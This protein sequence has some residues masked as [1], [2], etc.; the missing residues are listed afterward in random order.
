MV[1]NK[2]CNRAY[3]TDNSSRYYRKPMA[4]SLYKRP[5]AL[6]LP[7]ASQPDPAI[8]RRPKRPTLFMNNQVVYGMQQYVPP[9]MSPPTME[10]MAMETP[11]AELPKNY[12]DHLVSPHK[13][14]S[15]GDVN[16]K[17]SNFEEILA[18]FE[19]EN[20][21]QQTGS[22]QDIVKLSKYLKPRVPSS[23]RVRHEKFKSS[24]HSKDGTAKAGPKDDTS[25]NPET[26]EVTA[27]SLERLL[28]QLKKCELHVKGDQ[29]GTKNDAS[30]GD[31]QIENAETGD[32][33]DDGIVNVS[34]DEKHPRPPPKSF[35]YHDISEH[36]M[37][38]HCQFDATD[39]TSSFQDIMKNRTKSA[40]DSTPQK[41]R[42]VNQISRK[43]PMDDHCALE[44]HRSK[45]YIV[46]LIDRA[47]SKE[48][49]TVP[50]ERS[51][52]KFE[53]M[54]P[55]KAINAMNRH[56]GSDEKDIS[57]KITSA[58][59]DSLISNVTAPEVELEPSIRTNRAVV[60]QKNPRT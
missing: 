31:V 1:P 32:K 33:G 58:L 29:K 23:I 37:R 11:A 21:P 50:G 60:I 44:L 26:R 18:K 51:R 5:S 41:P 12:V 48:L 22:K 3:Y 30:V 56:G 54:N 57:V 28:N 19:R 46:N 45:S 40:T 38:S 43:P 49:G 53:N 8:Y 7:V 13:M 17:V 4:N 10:T 52:R 42:P 27:D 20:I 59:T 15:E 55:R 35:N 6:C 16:V 47:L 36:M 14:D 2:H 9:V 39:S 25:N 24:K 34:D